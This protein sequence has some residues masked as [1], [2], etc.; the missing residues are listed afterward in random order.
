MTE[1]K[2]QKQSKGN[3]GQILFILGAGLGTLWVVK[4]E[5]MLKTWLFAHMFYLILGGVAL[6]ICIGKFIMWRM[7]KKSKEF[8]ER[9]EQMQSLKAKKSQQD[10]YKNPAQANFYRRRGDN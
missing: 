1:N 10:F 9:A 8:L 3:E 7:K 2:N 5:V 4:N 6:L